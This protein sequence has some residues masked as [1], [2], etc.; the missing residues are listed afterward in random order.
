[1]D[2]SQDIFLDAVGHNDEVLDY[3]CVSCGDPARLMRMQMLGVENY[4]LPPCTASKRKSLFI[5]YC[6]EC[7]RRTVPSLLRK[8]A[9]ERWCVTGYEQNTFDNMLFRVSLHAETVNAYLKKL[10]YQ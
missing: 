9:I 10:G 1:M 6:P 3:T 4:D 8:E 2:I 5:V 7:L